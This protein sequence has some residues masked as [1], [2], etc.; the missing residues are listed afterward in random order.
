[1]QSEAVPFYL[2]NTCGTTKRWSQ[3]VERDICQKF[4]PP[5]A[6]VKIA[7]TVTPLPKLFQYPCS[8][9]TRR[10][11]QRVGWSLRSCFLKVCVRPVLVKPATTIVGKFLFRE[12]DMRSSCA[13]QSNSS[14]Q[15]VAK[16]DKE[17]A[18]ETKCPIRVRA[19]AF[20]VVDRGVLPRKAAKTMGTRLVL[21]G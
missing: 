1:M 7:A 20:V 13:F 4:I 11:I 17:L 12:V 14:L 2:R 21:N 15:L 6:A 16:I 18:I 9:T 8:Q 10:V 19:S 3:S 5:K